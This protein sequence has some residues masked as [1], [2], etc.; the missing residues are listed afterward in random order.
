MFVTQPYDN[1]PNPFGVAGY[2]PHEGIKKVTDSIKKYFE[3]F[4][5]LF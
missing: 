4:F 5:F 1:S 2:L 3:L